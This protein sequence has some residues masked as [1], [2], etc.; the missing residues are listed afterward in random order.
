MANNDFDNKGGYERDVFDTPPAGPAGVHRGNRSAA[1]RALPFVV[2]VVVAALCG[3]LAWGWFS[4]ELGNIRWPW[5]PATTSQAASDGASK[6][7]GK[8]K[9]EGKAK[10]QASDQ[11]A[12]GDASADGDASATPDAQ[13]DASASQDQQTPQD[14]Q[15]QQPAEQPQQ[16]AATVDKAT[17]VRV[18]NGTRINGYAASK[19]AQLQGS[20]YTA[21]SAGN[22]TGTL[23]SSTVVWYQSEA[24]K[25]TAEDVAATLGIANVQQ[26]ANISA[27][28]VVVLMS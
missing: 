19:A 6:D 26:L 3:M 9:D 24:Q 15:A 5:Q 1:A 21:V 22:P 16:P 28:V 12:E 13:Q 7:K 27:P 20:G 17:A 11:S 23:P 14:T 25:A 18:V 2:I 8:T 10:D 4:G